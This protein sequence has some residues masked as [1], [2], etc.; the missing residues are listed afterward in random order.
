MLFE[1][2]SVEWATLIAISEPFFKAGRM[3]FMIAS[4]YCNCRAFVGLILSLIYYFQAA[5]RRKTLKTYR[6][7]VNL[8][9]SC[10]GLLVKVL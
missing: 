7:T 1:V 9:L 3:E 2:L 5:T 10:F 6:A 4:S 8:S